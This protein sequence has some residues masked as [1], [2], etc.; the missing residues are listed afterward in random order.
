MKYFV[1]PFTQNLDGFEVDVGPA[2]DVESLTGNVGGAVGPDG[3]GNIDII[4]GIGC[5]TTGTPGSNI[6]TIDVSGH[7]LDWSRVAGP[8]VAMD[9]DNGYIPTNAALVT[10]TLPATADLGT[11]I[12]ILGEGVG[13]WLIAQN[14]GQ[15]IQFGNDSTTVGAGGSLASVNQWDTVVLTC[16]VADTTWTAIS[17]SG[18]I[19]T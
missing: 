9:V 13:G 12:E 7:G 15:S 14:A 19:V 18:L 8:A 17:N 1:N 5:T 11:K 16:R 4:G 6:I 2:S 10:F 3:A